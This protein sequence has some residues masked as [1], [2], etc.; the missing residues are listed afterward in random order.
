MYLCAGE[1]VFYKQRTFS[2]PQYTSYSITA[3][4]E[5]VELIKRFC[6]RASTMDIEFDKVNLLLFVLDFVLQ[7]TFCDTYT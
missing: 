6:Q 1:T 3:S 4:K 2:N 5:Q 7:L